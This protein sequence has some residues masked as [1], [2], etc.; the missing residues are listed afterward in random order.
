M[1]DELECTPVL[2][3]KTAAKYLYELRD[4]A[5]VHEKPELLRKSQDISNNGKNSKQTK[6]TE[7]I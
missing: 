4:F 2:G 1:E 3:V 7:Y 6:T 5:P